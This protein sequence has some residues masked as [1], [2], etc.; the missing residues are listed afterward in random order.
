MEKE[1]DKDV[2]QGEKDPD[3]VSASET[4]E[5]ADDPKVRHLALQRSS[6]WQGL[7]DVLLSRQRPWQNMRRRSHLEQERK[8]AQ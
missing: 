7:I 6:A 5:Q 4:A 3:F 8:L 1:Q 2:R